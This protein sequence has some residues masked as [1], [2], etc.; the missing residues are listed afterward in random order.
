MN[1]ESKDEI[2]PEYRKAINSMAEKLVELGFATRTVIRDK[3][4]MLR[5]QFTRQGKML[6]D[7]ISKVFAAVNHGERLDLNELQAFMVIMAMKQSDDVE[8]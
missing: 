6:Q 7:Q 4:G 8:Q 5:I 1:E 2:T 3:D